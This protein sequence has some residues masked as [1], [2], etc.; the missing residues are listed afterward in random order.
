VDKLV[1]MSQNLSEFT[2]E[3]FD[4]SN[5]A[6]WENKIRIGQMILYRCSHIHSNKKLCQ[7]PATQ[8]GFCKRHYIQS[9]QFK[10]PIPD[11]HK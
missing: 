2:R 10:H 9:K 11:I 3:F 7:Q 6:W 8:N 1:I 4:E 5:K